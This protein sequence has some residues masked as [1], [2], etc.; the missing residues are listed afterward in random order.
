MFLMAQVDICLDFVGYMDCCI[1][2]FNCLTEV[3]KEIKTL[4]QV[5]YIS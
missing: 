2:N 5:N 3:V 4:K 1:T